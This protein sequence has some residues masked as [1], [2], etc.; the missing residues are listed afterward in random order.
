[1]KKSISLLRILIETV[2]KK[3]ENDYKQPRRGK[4][5]TNTKTTPHKGAFKL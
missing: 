2:P 3:S 1:M 5:V 4:A